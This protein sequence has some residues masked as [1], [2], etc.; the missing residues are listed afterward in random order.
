M[1]KPLTLGFVAAAAVLASLPASAKTP[2]AAPVIAR[3]AQGRLSGLQQDGVKSFLGVPYAAPPVGELRWKPPQPAVIWRTIRPATLFGANCMQ[4]PTTAGAGAYTA[5]YLPAGPISEDCLS[6]SIWAPAKV[7]Q[8]APVLVW[9]HG[10]GFA[11][12]GT[13]VPAYEG[14]ALARRGIVVVSI[15]YRLGAFGFMP[16]TEFRN[17]GGGN[18]GLLDQIA[19]LRWVKQNI[20]AFGGDSSRVII[21]GESAGAASVHNLIMAKQAA[22]LFHGA[23]PMSGVGLGLSP[24]LDLASRDDAEKVG[25][26]FLAALEVGSIAEARRLSAAQVLAARAKVAGSFGPY[27]DGAL[28]PVD[29]LAELR[30]GRYNDTPVLLG[31]NADEGSALNPNYRVSDPVQYEQLLEQR[32]GALAPEAEKL[33]PWDNPSPFPSLI[34]DSGVA[35][36]L[37]WIAERAKTSRHPL[38][39]YVYS[40]V[41]PGPNSKRFGAFHSSGLPYIFDTLHK[42]PE[43]GFTDDDRQVAALLGRYW[44]NFVKRGDPNG[45]G[46]P[47]WPRFRSDGDIVDLSSSVKSYPPL[48]QDKIDFFAKHLAGGG[49]LLVF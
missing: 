8:K 14:T 30:A 12:G 16:S 13:S 7:R 27:A 28:L 48:P 32:F 9:I 34:R 15:N 26:R 35:A 45:P 46:L 25:G 4:S 31:L 3:V 17:T 6:L 33:Y 23:I 11:I 39:A 1:I 5:E 10:G 41:E 47:M 29:M 36:L 21:S 20:S 40:H 44:S 18:F 2:G 42:T 43:R 37:F 24:D 22:G 38:F 19:A 49:R